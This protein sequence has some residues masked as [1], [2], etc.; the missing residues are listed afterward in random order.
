MERQTL[1]IA[2]G[3]AGGANRI[4]P[5]PRCR[6]RVAA[7]NHRRP[8]EQDLIWSLSTG[9]AHGPSAHGELLG[10]TADARLHLFRQTPLSLRD[11]EFPFPLGG[12]G[13]GRL[14]YSA[15][16]IL[17]GSG[18]I[19]TAQ[20]GL[21]RRLRAGAAFQGSWSTDLDRCVPVRLE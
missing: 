9:L 20:R 1:G 3:I 2:A 10:K 5:P 13:R 21:D 19:R 12:G 15:A 6:Y 8:A 17:A 11:L 4:S 18:Q 7:R 14:H 16:G